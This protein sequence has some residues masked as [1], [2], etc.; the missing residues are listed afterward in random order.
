MLNARLLEAIL[1]ITL[2]YQISLKISHDKVQPLRKK[3]PDSVIELSVMQFGMGHFF[4]LINKSSQTVTCM[5]PILDN[6]LFVMRVNPSTG[7]QSSYHN[8]FLKSHPLNRFITLKP[9]ERREFLCPLS[10]E[11]DVVVLYWPMTSYGKNRGKPGEG[12]YMI[13]LHKEPSANNGHRVRKNN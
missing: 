12:C 9:F 11:N 3:D 7:D 6:S 10:F 8:P 1:F 13:Y 4:W 5:P 2:G